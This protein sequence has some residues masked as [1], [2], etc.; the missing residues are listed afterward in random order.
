MRS[1]GGD[2]HKEGSGRYGLI[3]DEAQSPI[4]E[5]VGRV[6]GG[7]ITQVDKLAILVDRVVV[8]AD[9]CEGI[10]EIPALRDPVLLIR[11]ADPEPAIEGIRPIACARKARRFARAV[12]VLILADERRSV[13]R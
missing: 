2:Q 11:G 4:F 10:P 6:V 9:G 13:T 3:L 8:V 5:Q 12:A 1:F 7:L